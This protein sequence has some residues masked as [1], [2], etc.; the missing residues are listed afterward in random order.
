MKL[1][2]GAAILLLVVAAFPATY[3]PMFVLGGVLDV[4]HSIR[5]T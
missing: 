3:I 2:A 5:G 4:I 1:L